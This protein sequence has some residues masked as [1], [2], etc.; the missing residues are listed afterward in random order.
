MSK[1]LPPAGSGYTVKSGKR[2][3]KTVKT[4]RSTTAFKAAATSEL[5]QGHQANPLPQAPSSK[6]GATRAR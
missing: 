1:L 4:G 3:S 2:S 6:G 5:K